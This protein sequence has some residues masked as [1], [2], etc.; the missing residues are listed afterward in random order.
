MYV[1]WGCACA[2]WIT[3]ADYIKYQDSGLS[4]HCIFIEPASPA[5]NIPADFDLTKNNITIKGQ[6]YTNE[7][8]PART[9]KS[10]EN[11]E[12]ARVF[13]YTELKVILR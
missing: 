10:E 1:A 3:P 4:K 13:R 2:N 12:K 7:G 11:L 8:Y 9:I 5:L 6:F